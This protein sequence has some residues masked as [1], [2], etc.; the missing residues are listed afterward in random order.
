MSMQRV[1]GIVLIVV[2]VFLIV[3]GLNASQS[4]VDQVSSTV[5]GRFTQSTMGYLIAGIASG[6][7]GAFLA[8]FNPRVKPR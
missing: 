6:A 7:L 5:R 4:V 3:I 8:L 2:G 1:I